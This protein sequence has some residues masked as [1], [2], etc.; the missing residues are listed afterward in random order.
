MITVPREQYRGQIWVCAN[1]APNAREKQQF[2]DQR[3]PRLKKV[4][5]DKEHDPL[6]AQDGDRYR[7]DDPGTY[8]LEIRPKDGKVSL[9]VGLTYD[10]KGKSSPLSLFTIQMDDSTGGRMAVKPYYGFK[11]NEGAEESEVWLDV[12]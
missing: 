1:R 3:Y 5:G 9:P 10:E 11:Y 12:P 4:A 2:P 7:F 6:I 8:Y